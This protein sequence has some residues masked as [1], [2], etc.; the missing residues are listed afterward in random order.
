MPSFGDKVAISTL[1]TSERVTLN[2]GMGYLPVG[3]P[4]LMNVGNVIIAVVPRTI[5]SFVKEKPITLKVLPEI[6]EHET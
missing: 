6:L 5:S 2:T 3:V 1:L 4:S